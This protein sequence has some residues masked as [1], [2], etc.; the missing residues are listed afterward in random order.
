EKKQFS[1]FIHHMGNSPQAL[2]LFLWNGSDFS[3]IKDISMDLQQ[4]ILLIGQSHHA[5][6]VL[7]YFHAYR[8][9]ESLE[10]TLCLIDEALSLLIERTDPDQWNEKDV[11]PLRQS[12]T[13]YL[14]T[15]K[16]TYSLK[17]E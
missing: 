2:L 17:A 11:L 3:R 1:L 14:E 5:Y 13:N 12:I 16:K 7:R 4:K 8:K 15:M 10:V 6:P 9:E